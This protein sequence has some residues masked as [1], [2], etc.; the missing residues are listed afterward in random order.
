M[1][2]IFLGRRYV[3]L[4]VFVCILNVIF[5]LGVVRGYGRSLLSDGNLTSQPELIVRYENGTSLFRIEEDILS[6]KEPTSRSYRGVALRICSTQ[7]LP[8]V[9]QFATV[10]A[11]ETAD[12]LV[13]NFGY[14]PENIV[15]LR[16]AGC[17]PD[18]DGK[19]APTEIWALYNS[20]I[21][22]T[23][24]ESISYSN[25]RKTSLG[26]DPTSCRG[27]SRL[28]LS[29]MIEAITHDK[30][31]FGIVVGYYLH[32]PAKVLTQN[33]KK[34]KSSLKRRG[35][36]QSRYV[37]GLVRWHYGTSGCSDSEPDN[38]GIFVIRM[39]KQ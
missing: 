20:K 38:P 35:I 16:S 10:D 21:L 1:N 14:K 9:L 3:F 2:T 32:S 6:L 26:F 39:H 28:A 22:P 24:V 29:K 12:Y 11:F 19:L 25:I 5:S 4:V 8:L 23:N 17:S 33:L 7:K 18:T 13:S 34:I 31:S 30:N 36:P 15:F 27:G 37:V